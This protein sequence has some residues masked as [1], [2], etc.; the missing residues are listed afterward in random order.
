MLSGRWTTS[1]PD[2]GECTVFGCNRFLIAIF[3]SFAL[4]VLLLVTGTAVATALGIGGKNATPTNV[5]AGS[6]ADLVGWLALAYVLRVRLLIGERGFR[7]VRPVRAVNTPMVVSWRQVLGIQMVYPPATH[8]RLV[9][10]LRDGKYGYETTI[11]LITYGTFAAR[12][13]EICELMNTRWAAFQ[14]TFRG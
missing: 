6:V 13:E 3:A 10:S 11:R 9:I 14:R 7:Y 8:G 5:A 4:V 12:G 2:L 1:D